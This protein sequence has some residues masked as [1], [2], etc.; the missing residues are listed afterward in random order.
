MA[1][2]FLI[3]KLKSKNIKSQL[4]LHVFKFNESLKNGQRYLGFDN[5]L[6]P[7]H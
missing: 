3:K 1:R 6:N 7:K 2:V 4:I 5:K